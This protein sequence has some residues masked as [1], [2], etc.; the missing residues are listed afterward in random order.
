MRTA[1]GGNSDAEIKTEQERLLN[2]K[3]S[4]T[5]N[6]GTM[7][8]RFRN[9]PEHLNNHENQSKRGFEK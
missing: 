3:Q 8:D 7:V 2:Q 5:V 4:A 9:K 6:I 1:S